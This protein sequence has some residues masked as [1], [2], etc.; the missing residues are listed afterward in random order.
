MKNSTKSILRLSA[1]LVWRRR[2]VLLLVFVANFAVTA[3]SG[4][5]FSQRLRSLDYSLRSQL[6]VR[7]MDVGV[8][9]EVLRRPEIGRPGS[10][11]LVL[12]QFVYLVLILFLT[13]GILNSYTAGRHLS[14]AEFFRDCGAFFWR[15]VR[16]LLFLAAVTILITV[17]AAL[18]SAA[19]EPLGSGV[20][21][22]RNSVLSGAAPVALWLFLFSIVRLWFDMAQVRAVL[23]GERAMRRTVFRAF[24]QA[25]GNFVQLFWLFL[26]PVI[27][28]SIVSGAAFL[29]WMSIPAHLFGISIALWEIVILFW[30]TMRLWQRA[31]EIVWYQHQRYAEEKDQSQYSLSRVGE[32]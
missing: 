15:F 10:D 21:Q 13:G 20:N 22:D 29:I 27:L 6:L 17:I 19:I 1:G 31:A 4:L 7:G 30:I 26:R 24:R 9:S 28:G 23:E 3:L 11:M 12:P 2:N 32:C 14:M 8:L 16:L 5:P 25:F 18:F